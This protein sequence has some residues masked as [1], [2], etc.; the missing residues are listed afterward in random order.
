M[1]NPADKHEKRR[2][3][4]DLMRNTLARNM[5]QVLGVDHNPSK[6]SALARGK[7]KQFADEIGVT[8][9]C[10]SNYLAGSRLPD[11]ALLP[12]L[13]DALSDAAGRKITIDEMLLHRVPNQT[14]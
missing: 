9:A 2:I 13:A 10:V 7:V 4:K 12:D 8:S 11:V 6:P 1:K 14:K 3:R 5:R